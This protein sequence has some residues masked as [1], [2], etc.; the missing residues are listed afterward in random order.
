MAARLREVLL[1]GK[2]IANTNCQ[3]QL[4]AIHWEQAIQRVENLNTIAALTFHLTYYLKGLLQV[5]RGGNLEISD[6]YSYD[7]AEITTETDW[8]TLVREFLSN[9]E[10]FASQIQQLDDSILAKPFVDEQYGSYLRNIEGVIEHSYYHL[11]QIVVIKKL[12]ESKQT[13]G[14]AGK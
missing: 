9:A 1:D 2:W 8:N 14:A 4:L 10:E 7:F 3:E 12:V 11:G 13:S 5:F 6:K